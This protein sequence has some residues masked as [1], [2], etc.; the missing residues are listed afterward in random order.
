ML[1]PEGQVAI[2]DKIIWVACTATWS[3]GIVWA[4]AAAHGYVWV[5]GS[6]VARV[7][8]DVPLTAVRMTRV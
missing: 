8:V 3:H 2:G 6:A 1:V 5:H 4:Q 7:Q